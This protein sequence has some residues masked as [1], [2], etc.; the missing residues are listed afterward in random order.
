MT[1]A[2]WLI[3]R[4]K[5]IGASEVSAILGLSPFASPMSVYADKLGLSEPLDD[6]DGRLAWGLMMEPAIATAY[7]AQ[8]GREVTFD[9]P[10]TR[11]HYG[12]PTTGFE[13][14]LSC[15]LDA[16]TCR[17]PQILTVY[18]S[19]WGP[20]ELK[21]VD[22]TKW[23]EWESGPPLHYQVQLQAQMACIGATWGAIASS[24]GGRPPV[25]FDIERDDAFIEVMLQAA[26][27]FWQLVEA[28]TPP[29]PD[30]SA[31]T[32]RALSQLY[33]KH[34]PGLRVTL[35]PEAEI[36]Y[37]MRAEAKVVIKEAEAQI[38]EAEAEIKASM[39]DAEFGEIPGCGEVSW[40]A[41]EQKAYEVKAMT[42]RVLRVRGET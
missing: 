33:R 39:G 20:L 14:N 18:P 36:W 23:D 24:I 27:D 9:P 17:A 13:P 4:R 1:R 19:A 11:H 16:R 32:K 41:Q 7:K 5:S 42:K 10:Y 22:S 8:T 35:P 40:R 30:P 31:A 12:S 28:R 6:S 26:A 37:R 25:S 29:P 2:E 21:T 15:T 3:A 34:K 38:A